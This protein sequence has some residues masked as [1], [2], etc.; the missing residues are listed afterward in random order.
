MHACRTA[1]IALL[2]AVL[3][4]CFSSEDVLEKEQPR[5]ELP[6]VTP[7]RRGSASGGGASITLNGDPVPFRPLNPT[8]EN[9][10]AY[11]GERRAAGPEGS[12]SRSSKIAVLGFVATDQPRVILSVHGRAHTLA[13]GMSVG[14]VH[15]EQISPPTV[16]LRSGHSTWTASMFDHP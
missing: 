8:R 4:G 1:T 3:G 2:V 16:T 11:G 14:A 10:F 15:V 7:I 13:A 6:R 5:T 9:P 12:P